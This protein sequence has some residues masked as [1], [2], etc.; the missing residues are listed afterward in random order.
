L[1]HVKFE[2][3]LSIPVLKN[4]AT[5]HKNLQLKI[6]KVL[7]KAMIPLYFKSRLFQTLLGKQWVKTWRTGACQ[8]R[9]NGT[10]L[11]N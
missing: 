4:R 10:Y 2:D 3:G 1:F 5:C 7:K 8:I 11:K 6:E 9:M